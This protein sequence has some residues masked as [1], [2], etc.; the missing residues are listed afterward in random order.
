MFA[1]ICFALAILHTFSVKRFAHT[2]EG[3][4]EG[5]VAENFFRLLG[6]VEVVFGLWAA[7]FVIFFAMTQGV[8]DAVHYLESLNF[9]EPAFVFV[10]MTVCSSKPILRTAAN[11]IA[12]LSKLIPVK[13]P[14]AFY[15][16][17]LIVGPLLGSFISEPAAMTVTA[18]I[19]L[20][21]FYKKG[22]SE[23]LMY[24]TLGLL[25]VNISIGGTLTPYSAPPVIMVAAKWN[26]DLP[27]M[28]KTF[29]WK[30][31]V[32][33]VASTV[34]VVFRFRKELTNI[35]WGAE[36]VRKNDGTP[37]WVSFV[38][39]L[40]LGLIVMSSHYL[41]VFTGIFLF[42]LGLVSVTKE[43]QDEIKLREGLLVAFF[44]GGLVVLGGQQRWWLEPIL[45][46]L[47][48]FPLYIGAIALTAVMDNAALT[49]LGS[50]VPSLGTG[51]QYALVAG[52]VTGGGLTVIANA[53]NPAGYGIL[54][55]SFGKEGISPLL[56]LFH[57]LVPTG[58]AA[59]CFWFF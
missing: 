54:N 44:L 27:F 18:L 35:P 45:T 48:A 21:R 59:L 40:F 20:E 7:I 4:S 16:V 42:F 17:C 1:T 31:A 14:I 57:A 49:Y 37:L 26:W 50:Q 29:G 43:Y 38:H 32:A 51:L 22:I 47:D 10:I 30:A 36:D 56:L 25:F 24:T 46:Q 13:K 5:S 39:I 58:V 28:L 33:I 3:Y 23:K 8:G 19:L 53:P 34:F 6:E 55:R 11:L 15:A 41:V 2:A 12:V 52:A 9:T